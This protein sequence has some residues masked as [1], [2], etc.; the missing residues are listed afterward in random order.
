M[1]YNPVRAV[2]SRAQDAIYGRKPLTEG[3]PLTSVDQLTYSDLQQ[4]L[5]QNGVLPA[6]HISQ[7]DIEVWKQ[8]PVSI[9]ARLRLQ[10]KAAPLKAPTDLL[11]KFT[12]SDISQRSS[13]KRAFREVEFYRAVA[14][15]M[16]IRPFPRCFAA[17][18]DAATGRSH[19][20]LED[21]SQHYHRAEQALPATLQNSLQHVSSLA[22][23]HSYWWND[24]RLGRTVGSLPSQEEVDQTIDDFRH[25]LIAFSDMLG[26]RLTPTRR[27][28]LSD[29][30]DAMPDIMKRQENGPITLLHG[31]THPWNFLNPNDPNS[32]LAYIIDWEFWRPGYP[33]HDLAYMLAVNHMAEHRRCIETRLLQHYLT[34]LTENGV[35]DLSWEN[36]WD[37]YRL[38]VIRHVF[39]PLVQWHNGLA[40]V[41]WWGNIDRVIRA[42]DELNCKELLA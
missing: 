15:S 1:P 26:D 27:K 13:T 30:C 10:Y 22:I 9:L 6:G 37:Q 24:G 20:L 3:Y 40:N 2:I 29:V 8:T 41:V 16:P 5:R 18:Y 7:I 12:R 23:V 4:C 19:L 34:A 31:D 39:T 36:C 11:L 42:F 21:L 33:L 38:A 14:P 17:A 28:T 25:Y 35:T 32:G